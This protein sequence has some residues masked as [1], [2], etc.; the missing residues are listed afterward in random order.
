MS[1]TS[2]VMISKKRKMISPMPLHLDGIL[3]SLTKEILWHYDGNMWGKIELPTNINL[4]IVECVVDGTV[5]IAGHNGILIRGGGSAW[6]IID[7]K[8]TKDDIWD[9]EWFDGQLYVSTMHAVYRLIGDNLEAVDFGDDPPRSCY[10][11]SAAKG[12]IWSNGEFDIMSFDGKKWT[13]VI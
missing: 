10:Q 2:S 5:Y 6:E 11:L 9:I 12:V 13:R 7:H 8:E 4:S 1:D 3:A